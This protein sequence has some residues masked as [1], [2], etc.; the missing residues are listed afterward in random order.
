M[1]VGHDVRRLQVEGPIGLIPPSA[2]MAFRVDA[3][4]RLGGSETKQLHR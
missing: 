3:V 4:S 1:H 2:C